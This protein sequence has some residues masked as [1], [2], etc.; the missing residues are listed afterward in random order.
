MKVTIIVPETVKLMTK[1]L[2]NSSG[3]TAVYAWEID[4]QVHPTSITYYVTEFE[5]GNRLHN[6]GNEDT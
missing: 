5:K 1:L 2:L 4:K 3:I 6:N